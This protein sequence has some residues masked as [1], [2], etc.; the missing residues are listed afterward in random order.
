MSKIYEQLAGSTDTL[1]NA[2]LSENKRLR[3]ALEQ[4][5]WFG[6]AGYFICLWCLNR[7]DDG[8]KPDCTRQSALRQSEEQ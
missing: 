8:H 2:L 1:M 3:A 4:V 7:R 6:F 5:E